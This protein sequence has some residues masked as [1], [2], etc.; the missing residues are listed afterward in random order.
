MNELDKVQDIFTPHFT[1][2]VI[3]KIS[4]I[5]KNRFSARATTRK[6]GRILVTRWTWS[7]AVRERYY[8]LPK[9]H[10]YSR[11]NRPNHETHWL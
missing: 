3:A 11:Q 9:N 5:P 2:P 4:R 8:P 6:L 1:A 10:H 7:W